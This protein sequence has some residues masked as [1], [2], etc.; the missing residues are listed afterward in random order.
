[1]SPRHVMWML[2]AGV[3]ALGL[4]GCEDEDYDHVP[5]DGQGS[6]IL[7]NFTGDDIYVFIDGTATNRLRD[8]KDEAYD[9]DPGVHRLVLDQDGGDRY[10]AWDVDVIEGRLTI[11][12]VETD[13]W[14]WDDYE[15]TI[16][17]E[18]P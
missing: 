16:H 14:N 5:P 9:L 15:V 17:L 4:A 11:V 12:D 3:L 18:T 6:I 13:D 2:I 10:G 7:D 8:Y 1:M